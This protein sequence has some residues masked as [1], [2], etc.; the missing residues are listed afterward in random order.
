[1]SVRTA[2]GIRGPCEA[3]GFRLILLS[4]AASYSSVMCLIYTNRPMNIHGSVD[5][6]TLF[7]D[8]CD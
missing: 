5:V 3:S 6:Q 4:R 8:T 1:M 7:Y 2:L